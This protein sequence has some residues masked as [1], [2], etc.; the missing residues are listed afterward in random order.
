MSEN[1]G[2][3]DNPGTPIVLTDENFEEALKKYNLL[4]VDFWAAWCMPCK[5]IAPT[6]DK[7]AEKHKGNIVFGK[8]NI[9][10]NHSIPTKFN[11]MS[12]P[13]LVV[14]KDGQQVDQIVG[15]V[16]E[17]TIEEKILGE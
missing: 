10:E 16:P 1:K 15:V 4:V 7:L 8:M 13:T 5:M 11:I 2:L 17:K 12:I 14:F 9:D 3:I 6:I